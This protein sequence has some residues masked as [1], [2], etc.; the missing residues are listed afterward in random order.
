MAPGKTRLLLRVEQD[1]MVSMGG[2]AGEALMSSAVPR[3]RYDS[4]RISPTTPMTAARVRLLDLDLTTRATLAAAGIT[5]ATPLAYIVAAPY[6]ADCKTIRYTDTTAWTVP[7][8]TGYARATLASRNQWITGVP[9]FVIVEVW[10]YPF[11]RQRSRALFSDSRAPIA[12]AR[13]LFDFNNTV[14]DNDQP[15]SFPIFQDAAQVAIAIR[16][17]RANPDD[18]EREPIRQLVRSGILR[19]DMQEIRTLPSR[20]R[21][22]YRVTMQAD[23]TTVQ[24]EFRTVTAA[25]YAWGTRD[26][27]RTTADIVASPYVSG[28]Q[29][30]GYGVDSAGALLTSMLKGSASRAVPHVWLSAADHPARPV[31]AGTREFQADL[32]FTR[33]AA[34]PQIWDALDAYV[35]VPSAST[36]QAI[37]RI[38]A[39]NRRAPRAEEQP[40]IPMTLRMQNDGRLRG[41]TTIVRNGRTLRVTLDRVDSVH[42]SNR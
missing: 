8:D 39:M 36:R 35:D 40:H 31:T 42:Y 29:L 16:W 37:V 3:G 38:A 28:T 18:A 17:A 19:F 15:F 30:V 25:A 24:W 7:G 20:L 14:M 5:N 9:V 2:V 33:F 23:D 32:M 12:S 27:A 6:R 11:P 41:D 21:G 1:T 4:S 13:A 22:T 26:A 34:P 10:S